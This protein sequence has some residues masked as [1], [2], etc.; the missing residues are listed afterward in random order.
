VV[1]DVILADHTSV[2]T[3]T[4]ECVRVHVLRVRDPR[5]ISSSH[6]THSWLAIFTTGANV[7]KRRESTTLHRAEIRLHLV[8]S[9]VATGEIKVLVGE[10]LECVSVRQCEYLD[11]CL[12]LTRRN[13][14]LH[15]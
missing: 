8:R 6:A 10:T 2:S 1:L 14:A 11:W 7:G 15:L 4:D 12:F 13:D 3:T 5:M 9:H